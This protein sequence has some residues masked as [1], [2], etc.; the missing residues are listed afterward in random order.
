MKQALSLRI[1]VKLLFEVLLDS[2]K[3]FD[4]RTDVRTV[5]DIDLYTFT[6]SRKS[7]ASFTVFLG[8]EVLHLVNL[9]GA[10]KS[11]RR[12]LINKL[13]AYVTLDEAVSVLVYENCIWFS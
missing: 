9:Y 13:A 3:F 12:D 5:N 7:S 10:H 11:L 8:E 1:T 4:R 6:N 2:T